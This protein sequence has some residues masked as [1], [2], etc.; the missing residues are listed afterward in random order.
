MSPHA[1]KRCVKKKR[2]RKH[3]AS[4]KKIEKKT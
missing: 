1:P 4:E 2:R 3:L